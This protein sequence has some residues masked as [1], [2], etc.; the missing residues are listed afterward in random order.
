MTLATS[1]RTS[2]IFPLGITLKARRK[3][4]DNLPAYF[5]FL[6]D[7]FAANKALTLL[8]RGAN[9]NLQIDLSRT[10]RELGTARQA[11]EALASGKITNNPVQF[12]LASFI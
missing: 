5:Y 10:I 8:K 7:E 1:L 9:G 3:G 11:A 2:G 4:R 6:T 12:S